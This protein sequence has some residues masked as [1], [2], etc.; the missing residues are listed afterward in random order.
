MNLVRTLIDSQSGAVV[1]QVAGKF[2]L[3]QSQAKGVVEALVSALA[4]GVQR[5]ASSSDGIGALLG[6]LS[7]GGHQRYVDQPDVL[8]QAS[9]VTVPW[10][11]IS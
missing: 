6:A 10:P 11:T 5:N 3:P 4:R 9:T 7:G 1:G 2:G 8:G